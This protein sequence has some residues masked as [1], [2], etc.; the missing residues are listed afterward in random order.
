MVELANLLADRHAALSISVLIITTT[1]STAAVPHPAAP[2]ITLLHLT[3]ENPPPAA[4]AGSVFAKIEAR[5]PQIR[6]A[7]SAAIGRSPDGARLAG[8][9]LDM[10]CTSMADVAG[11]FGV[12]YYIFFTSAAS[13][14]GFISHIQQLHDESGFDVAEFEGNEL[15][16][17]SWARP[18][19]RW[20]FP[21]N[22]VNKEWLQLLY[23]IARVF[24]RARG[25]LVN[26]VRELESCAVDSLSFTK[27][28]PRMTCS[29]LAGG[30][31]VPEEE[32]IEWLD[33]QPESSVVF[34]CFGSM[35]AFREEQVLEIANGLEASGL[36][37]LW[38]LRRPGPE[39]TRAG[40]T[41]YQDVREVLPK[42]FVDRTAGVGRVMGWAPQTIILAHKAVGGFVSHC[43]WNSTLESLWFGVPMATWP[44]Y[45]EQK[46]NAFLLVHEL[47]IA[48]EIKIDYR[49]GEIVTAEE[50]ERGVRRLM[51][52]DC[53]RE[54]RLKKF[55][56]CIKKALMD[57]G[58]SSAS[59]AEFIE[60]CKSSGGM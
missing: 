4:A 5:K 24:R 39:G 1:S 45:A 48:T 13:D 47:E 18:I 20:A 43:G 33:R 30:G 17:P 36:R 9:V 3:D 19:P 2:R 27:V 22:I 37:F 54:E 28:H 29:P 16:V 10:F 52:R 40:P 57:G 11:E 46:L 38:V 15:A 49:N 31:G 21:P 23:R 44:M 60:G 32:A 55:S 56:D 8:L 35:G 42:G 58:S 25:I 51:E 14:L 7:V 26:T 59:I 53:S 41:D 50:V 12:P 6:E 34:L